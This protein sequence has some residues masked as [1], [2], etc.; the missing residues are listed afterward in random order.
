MTLLLTWN[1][2]VRWA[3]CS[4]LPAEVAGEELAHTR[5]TAL[6]Q[7][8]LLHQARQAQSRLTGPTTADTNQLITPAGSYKEMSSILADHLRRRIRTQMRGE[9]GSCGVSTN[10]YSFTQEPVLRILV[11]VPVTF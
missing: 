2:K 7:L 1:G 9:G 5:L 3:R 4:P 10:E 11:R 6:P 8:T